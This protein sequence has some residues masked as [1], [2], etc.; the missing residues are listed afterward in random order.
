MQILKS[1]LRVNYNYESPSIEFGAGLMGPK[2]INGC[3]YQDVQNR[4][5]FERIHKLDFHRCFTNN[6]NVLEQFPL[7]LS[8]SSPYFDRNLVQKLPW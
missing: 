2:F 5:T 3:E 1:V 8:T 4:N 7:T 6:F